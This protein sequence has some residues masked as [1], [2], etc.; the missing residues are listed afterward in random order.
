[1]PFQ[2]L[3]VAYSILLLFSPSLIKDGER[4]I[5]IHQT[6]NTMNSKQNTTKK[7]WL[8]PTL[9]NLDGGETEVGSINNHIFEG[10]HVGISSFLGS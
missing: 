8:P 4:Q 7:I 1:L 10:T 6:N 3:G 5:N 2:I 9:M